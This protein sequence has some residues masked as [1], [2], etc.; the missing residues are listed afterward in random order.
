[1]H[2]EKHD[3]SERCHFLAQTI[4]EWTG[5]WIVGTRLT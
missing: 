3:S 4:K 5:L 2:K 1:M